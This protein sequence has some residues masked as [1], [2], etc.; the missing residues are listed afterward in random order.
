MNK[1]EALDKIGVLTN[2]IEELKA[3]VTS[4]G[5]RES[6]EMLN[7][8]DMIW[9]KVDKHNYCTDVNAGFDYDSH[10]NPVGSK[11]IVWTCEQKNYAYFVKEYEGH[12]QIYRKQREENN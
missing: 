8:D 12:V 10:W 11:P 7:L 6:W 2:T 9:T 1:Q 5:D 3:F 4:Y